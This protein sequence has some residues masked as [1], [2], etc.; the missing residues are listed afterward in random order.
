LYARLVQARVRADW[1]YRTS[2][3]I[4]TVGQV[5]AALLDFGAI[6]VIFSR[7]R[8]L[9]G[10]TLYD[11]LFLYATSG[12]AFGLGDLFV[13]P[14]ERASFHIRA[15][16]FDQFLLRPIGPLLQL[17]TEEFALR[18]VGKLVQPLAAFGLALGH[19]QLAWTPAK[20]LV[21][22]M[23]VGAGTVILSALWVITSSLSFW[24]VE[25]QEVAN[26]FTYGGGY[27]TQYPL[28]V[29]SPWL[30]RLLLLV[31]LAFVNYLPACWILGRPDSFGLPGWVRFS[32]PA[33]AALSVAVAAWVWRL[34][35]RHYR[36]TGS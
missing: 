29:L 7:V 30:R 31:P 28:D 6:L 19:L 34:A 8:A 12:V 26:A 18:R 16:S 3:I 10:W 11:V 2:T 22:G 32:S 25:T 9:A 14:V 27:T 33:V 17:T 35:I 1:Q 20:V 5:L 23:T 36:S 13:S 24:T 21:L 4:F 15:G